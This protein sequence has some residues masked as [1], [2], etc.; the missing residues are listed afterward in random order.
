MRSIVYLLV[1]MA[2]TASSTK[3][4]LQTVEIGNFYPD[5]SHGITFKFENNQAFLFRIGFLDSTGN[6]IK[7]YGEHRDMFEDESGQK[8]GPS[9]PDYSYNKYGFTADDGNVIWIEWSKTDNE[10][11][12]VGKIYSEKPANIYIEAMQAFPKA[13]EVYYKVQDNKVHGWLTAGDK[14]KIPD[15]QLKVINKTAEETYA[16]TEASYGLDEKIEKADTVKPEGLAS[17][18]ALKYHVSLEEPLYFYAGIANDNPTL[19]TID[20]R[21]AEKHKDYDNKRC[22]VHTPYGEIWEAVSN[23]LNNS[24]VYGT[25]IKLSGHVVSRGWCNGHNQ[26]L[27]EW[28]TF[29][30]ALLASL[31]DPEGARESVR[32]ILAHQTPLGIVPNNTYGNDTVNNSND[33]SQP[34]VGSICV[35]KMHQYQPDIEFLKEVYPKLLKWHNWWFDIRPED[36]LPYRDGNQNG[37]LEWGTE[38]DNW[39]QGAKYESGLDNSPMF[40]DARLNIKS[41][42]MELDMAGLSGLWAADALYLSYIAEELGDTG[43]AERLRTQVKEMN[44]RINRELWN[45]ELGMYCN[46]YWNEYSRKPKDDF[47]KSIPAEA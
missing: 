38:I 36:G 9:A 31:E 28:D 25:Q 10:K 37:L 32:A 27:F 5:V 29:F 1:F 44:N 45:E 17:A 2:L 42:T 21:L 41:G 30:H 11:G 43:E 23:H 46:K 39:L 4:E 13:P 16:V 8:F 7:T 14:S 26:R 19:Q 35:W 24:R 33:R 12:A 20:S 6:Y 3:K 15:W 47:F 22:K 18:G 34:P 40:D